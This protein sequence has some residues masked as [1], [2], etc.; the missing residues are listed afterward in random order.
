MTCREGTLTPADVDLPSLADQ[1]FTVF[2]GGFILARATG[3][4]GALQAQV[5]H[6][7]WYVSLLFDVRDR[8]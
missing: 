6:L 8:S 1:V 4:P 2:E 3:D 5:A 7:R